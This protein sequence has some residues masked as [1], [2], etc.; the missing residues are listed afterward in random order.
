MMTLGTLG[1]RI[2]LIREEKGWTQQDLAEASGVCQQMISKLET[3]KAHATSDIV[4]LAYA[5]RVSPAWLEGISKDRSLDTKPSAKKAKPTAQ[6][7]N[8]NHK[9]LQV[10]IEYLTKDPPKL[11]DRSGFR[12]QAETFAKCYELCTQAKNKSLSKEKMMSLLK[13][14]AR[15]F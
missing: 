11:F 12:R 10:C 1:K 7:E 13:R 5:L 15:N 6:G 3:G 2:K 8:L 9:A 14:R 4:K